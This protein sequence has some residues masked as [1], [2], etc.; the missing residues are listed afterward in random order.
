LRSLVE[1]A[2]LAGYQGLFVAVDNLDVLLV[3]RET[4]RVLYGRAAREEFYESVRQFLDEIATL[5]HLMIVL[6]FHNDL[7]ENPTFGIKSYAA[8]WLRIQ[9]EIEGT[10]VNLF[11]DFLD[12]DQLLGPALPSTVQKGGSEVAES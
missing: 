6:G 1:L 11:R 2:R 8:L 4:G 9:Y 10:R 5:H 3:R 12:L 7:V